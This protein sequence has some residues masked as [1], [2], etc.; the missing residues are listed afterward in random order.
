MP[1][2]AAAEGAGATAGQLCRPVDS[3]AGVLAAPI[4]A[5]AAPYK[6]VSLY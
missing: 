5:A 6:G 3:Q 4:P 2:T 1:T